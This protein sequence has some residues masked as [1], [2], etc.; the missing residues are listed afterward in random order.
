M[1][2]DGLFTNIIDN[3][4]AG[5]PN[6][7]AKSIISAVTAANPRGTPNWTSFTNFAGVTKAPL[8]SD[9]AQPILDHMLSPKT[10]HWNLNVQ[11]EL[12]GGFVSQVSYVGERGEHLY[13]QTEFNPQLNNFVSAARRI[14][15][16]GR[17]VLRDN[18]EDSNYNG[19]WAQVD[20][21]V[22]SH[23]AFRAAYTY[24]RGM[25]DGSEIF[26]TNNQSAYA[27]ITAHLH[28]ISGNDWCSPT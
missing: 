1:F 28:T 15:S 20:K 9:T 23:L 10:F 25:D 16:R 19:L 24:A 18:S 26:T 22:S 3:I 5:A 7:S 4:Q 27:R 8:P 14:S 12:P 6:N 2:Y 17:I 11:Q 21:K 13:G